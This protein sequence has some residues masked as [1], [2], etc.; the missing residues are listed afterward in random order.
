MLPESEGQREARAPPST[1]NQQG[2][3]MRTKPDIYAI[4]RA[5][6]HLLAALC[7]FDGY[8]ADALLL[9]ATGQHAI[10]HAP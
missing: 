9:R 3:T 7:D 6:F 4:D 1:I 8:R 10:M 2:D 5:Q